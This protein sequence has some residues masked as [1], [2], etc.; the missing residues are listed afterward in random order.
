MSLRASK[1]TDGLQQ[2][3]AW[4]NWALSLALVLVLHVGAV[5]L[6]RRPI[7]ATGQVEAQAVMMDLAPEPTTQ[8][9][10]APPA[11]VPP[12]PAPADPVPPHAEPPPSPEPPPPPRG[13]PPPDLA[14]PV[15]SPW[16]PVLPS[17]PDV[18]PPVPH[19]EIP[20]PPPPRVPKQPPVPRRR[21][22]VVQPAPQISLP[23]PAAAP[24]PMTAPP[25]PPAA[26]PSGQVVAT[27]QGQLLAHLARFKRFP[28]DAQRRGEQGTVMMQITMSHSGQVLSM[29]LAHSS[30]YADLDAEAQAW[31]VRAE[32]LPA[33]PPDIVVTQ[34]DLLVPLRFALR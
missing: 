29:S 20:L 26:P 10:A 11:P 15:L 28:M 9:D 33:F 4:T 2:S 27:W 12:E 1:P 30:G 24:P 21:Q 18:A 22:S 31:I 32:P 5:L 23:K 7:L 25:G 34:M 13:L 14:P 16:E 3:N 8:P 19:A 17:I 6:L